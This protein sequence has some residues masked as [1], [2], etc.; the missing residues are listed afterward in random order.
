MPFTPQL[1][2]PVGDVYKLSYYTVT[3]GNIQI[4]TCDYMG[5]SAPALIGS[6]L[7]ALV[8]LAEASFRANFPPLVTVETELFQVAIRCLSAPAQPTG[9]IGVTGTVVGTATGIPINLTVATVVTKR[10][11]LIGKHGRGRLYLPAVPA[12]FVEP[13][14]NRLTD[15]SRAVTQ[16]AMV[17]VLKEHVVGSI[18][19]KAAVSQRQAPGIA[20]A[21][22]GF[23]AELD[24][25]TL[26][27]NVRRRRLER[28]I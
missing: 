14:G 20:T 19:Y 26:L 4:F 25:R 2:F 3:Y 15:A 10:T 12:A 11:E 18:T 16:A 8:T 17:L 7:T 13:G 28:G 27:G 21:N 22:A 23:V 5:S 1:P 24:T 6:D 9:I